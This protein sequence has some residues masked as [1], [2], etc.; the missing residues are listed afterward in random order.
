GAVLRAPSGLVEARAQARRLPAAEAAARLALVLGFVLGRRLRRR[1]R[2]QFAGLFA[3]AQAPQPLPLERLP[4]S[5]ALRQGIVLGLLRRA[6]AQ[7][8]VQ[9]QRAQ[10]ALEVA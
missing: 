8:D 3:Q 6:D 4:G 7:R 5:P 2:R 1:F 9:A 10:V